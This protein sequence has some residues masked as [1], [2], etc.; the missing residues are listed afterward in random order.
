M[1][2]RADVGDFAQI[3]QLV[4][5]DDAA[6]RLHR[7]VGDVEAIKIAD[8]PVRRGE[9]HAGLTL[10]LRGYASDADLKG[11]RVLLPSSRRATF[12][13]RAQR[14]RRAARPTGAQRFEIW[15]KVPGGRDH[16]GLQAS[17]SALKARRAGARH[18]G[19]EAHVSQ[20]A[21]QPGTER[22]ESPR[23]TGLS[24]RAANLLLLI[25]LIGTLFPMFY[26]R[27]SP[28]FAGMPFFYWYQLLW[29]PLSVA[30]TFFVYRA[31]RGGRR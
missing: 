4:G 29:I 12:S 17:P 23:P 14:S 27:D 21:R 1:H 25:P 11:T 26:N 16:R 13:T 22:G 9:P 30:V 24:F 15:V 28:R 7:S 2:E 8:P 19:E 20:Q 5:I 10:G 31:T 6:D 3:P 18:C